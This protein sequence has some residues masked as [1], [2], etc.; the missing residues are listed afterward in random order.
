M[1]NTVETP[2]CI[3]I[4]LGTCGFSIGDKCQ[5]FDS[6]KWMKTGDIGNNECY[7]VNATITGFRQTD[8]N[9]LLIDVIIEDGRTSNG[10]YVEGVRHCA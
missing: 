4:L 10:Y 8:Y 2:N 6:E 9:E 1:M 3:N 7:W 5:V